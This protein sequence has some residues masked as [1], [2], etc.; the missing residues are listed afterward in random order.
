MND[1]KVGDRVE[2]PIV[3]GTGEVAFIGET[4]FSKGLWYGVILYDGEGRCD[5][6]VDGIRYFHCSKNRGIFIRSGRTEKEYGDTSDDRNKQHKLPSTITKYL[7]YLKANFDVKEF[8]SDASGSTEIC[9]RK[10]K[11][12]DFIVQDKCIASTSERKHMSEK[13][14][15]DTNKHDVAFVV[16]SSHSNNKV[17]Y[18]NNLKANFYENDS[19]LNASAKRDICAMQSRKDYNVQNKNARNNNEIKSVFQKTKEHLNKNDASYAPHSSSSNFRI[20]YPNYLKASSKISWNHICE[21]KHTDPSKMKYESKHG[22]REICSSKSS[23]ANC[24]KCLELDA[25]KSEMKELKDKLKVFEEFQQESLS[26]FEKTEKDIIHLRKE[27][28]CGRKEVDDKEY[29][30]KHGNCEICSSISTK[31]NC[32]K[33]LELVSVKIEIEEFK[34]RLKVIEESVQEILCKF[35]E[36]EKENIHLRKE[37]S[38]GRKQLNYQEY[39]SKLLEMGHLNLYKINNCFVDISDSLSRSSAT[40]YDLES[41]KAMISRQKAELQEQNEKTLQGLFEIRKFLNDNYKLTVRKRAVLS[42]SNRSLLIVKNQ[43]L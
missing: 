15:E 24:S 29:Q 9:K 12:E 34:N 23:K 16:H 10:P 39:Q 5:G 20:K 33:S 21:A 6:S 17:K 1:I 4:H 41:I 31:I 43:G 14:R 2:I 3:N 35:E 28:S 27:I 25:I 7:N 11:N 37:I 26:K 22:D 18:P 40:N 38:C 32:I 8:Y 36:T 19:H 13:E 30:Y 42:H